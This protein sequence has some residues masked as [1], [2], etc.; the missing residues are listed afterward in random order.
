MDHRIAR[1]TLIASLP[2]FAMAPLPARA[3]QGGFPQ[4]PLRI[5]APYAPG[6]LSD[7]LAALV[8][9][10]PKPLRYLDIYERG[11]LAKAL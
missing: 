5:I 7:I 2:A 6:G 1:R 8:H 9:K 4:R 3:Q 11:A 10:Y